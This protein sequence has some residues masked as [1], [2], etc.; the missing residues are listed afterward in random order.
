MAA[1]RYLLEVHPRLA[2]A[3]RNPHRVTEIVLG[4][5]TTS[6]RS[7]IE[8]LYGGVAAFFPE[9]WAR[10]PAGVP[11]A[12]RGDLIEAYHRLLMHPDPAIHVKAA[13]DWCEWEAAVLD[14]DYQPEPRRLQLPFQLA[15]GRIVTH[16]FRHNAWLEDGICLGR[17][18][19]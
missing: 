19:P 5:V 15:F 4:G 10:F 14:P 7:E 12:E 3:E 16:Y 18:V 6:R 11:A 9:Q 8:W 2:Y 13:K 1:L 17:W